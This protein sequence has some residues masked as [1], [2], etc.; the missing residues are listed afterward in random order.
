MIE[1]KSYSDIVMLLKGHF[2]PQPSAIICHYRF[3]SR[4][5]KPT[6]SVAAY[7]AELCNLAEHCKFGATLNEMIR[8]RLVCGITDPRIQY[9][10][11]QEPD[12]LTY[13]NTYK[14]AIALETAS[15]DV[16][17]LQKNQT[18]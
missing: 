17:D 13:N 3:N 2:D 9:R 15:K 6:E 11:L 8:D 18:Q 10:L 16:L 12:T 4:D 7:V 14:L 5:R 1:N